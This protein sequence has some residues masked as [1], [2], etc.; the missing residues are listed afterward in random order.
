[1]RHTPA[2][3]AQNASSCAPAP[4][5][6]AP[7]MLHRLAQER[8]TGAFTRPGGTLF[9]VE[10]R[11]AHAE[12][13]AA[14][15]LELLLAGGGSRLR[16]GR[17]H[18]A[19]P[20]G[21]VPPADGGTHAIRCLVEAGQIPGGMLELC[22]RLA[23]YDAAFFVLESAGDGPGRFREG[24][25][26][27]LEGTAGGAALGAVAL[28]AAERETARRRAL[29]DRVWPDARLDVLPPV[30]TAAAD[31]TGPGTST[32]GVPVRRPA[33]DGAAGLVPARRLA[34][35]ERADGV[36]NAT[37][38]A[39]ALGRPAFHT[40]MDLR[41]LAAAG[42]VVPR[43]AGARTD[44]PGRA[45][46]PVRTA[47]PAAPPG[48]AIAPPPAAAAAPLPS[49]PTDTAREGH[50]VAPPAVFPDPDVALLRRLRDALEGL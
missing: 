43:G 19:A 31:R 24:V 27:W 22:A 11:I 34:V 14:P 36:R 40:L 10:G 33:A 5:T 26:H 38:I 28:A 23:L 37:D 49:P 20:P 44:T 17:R 12:S 1:A 47:A 25:R 46:G 35:L 18:P 50:G 41:R 9:L 7:S 42:L 4:P 21:A 6:S 16:T 39:R 48:P 32:P 45:A 2:G 15:A 8:A 3:P 29:L 13:P 30:P